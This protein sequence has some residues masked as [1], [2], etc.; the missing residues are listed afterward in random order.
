MQVAPIDLTWVDPVSKIT[1]TAAAIG[2]AVWLARKLT[3][4]VD[5]NR[6]RSREQVDEDRSTFK[7]MLK[8]AADGLTGFVAVKDSLTVIVE[9]QRR[10]IE[11]QDHHTAML[12]NIQDHIKRK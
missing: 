10:Q 2:L 4:Y 9:L 12:Q 1:L 11:K 6:K 3:N 8:K 7:E 5:D